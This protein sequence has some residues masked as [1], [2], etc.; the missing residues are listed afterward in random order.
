MTLLPELARRAAERPVVVLDDDPTGTQAVRGLVVMTRWDVDGIARHLA[1]GEPGLFLSTNSRALAE[2]DAVA[3]TTDAARAALEAAERA[4]RPITIVSRGDSTLRGHFP[5]ETRAVASALGRPDA[6]VLLVPYFGEGGRLTLDDVHVLER[7]GARTPV[8]ETEFARDATFGYRA[9]NLRDW[10]V[11]KHAAAGIPPP[12][13]VSLPT[14]LVRDGPGQVATALLEVPPG[15]VAIG[16]AEADADV[17]TIALGSVLAEQD[18]L[19]LVP[20][21]AASFVRARVGQ[22]RAT[23]L[24]PANVPARG[25]GLVVVGSHVTTTTAQVER[26]LAAVPDL[27]VQELT[28]DAVLAGSVAIHHR[29][30]RGVD[31]ALDA[32]RTALVL[33]ERTRRDIDLAGGRAVSAALA[34]IV[35]AVRHRPGWVLAKGGITSFDVARDGLAMAEARIAGP[36]LPGVPVW[37][38][39]DASRWPGV[40][41]VVFPGNVGDTDALAEAV[42]RLSRPG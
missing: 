5:A 22:T 19:S 16:N 12:P 17:E 23:P 3:V 7:D 31:E 25:P 28:I 27:A 39:T 30:A 8:G 21:S 14:G 36:L 20:R 10:V 41:L 9:S 29:I 4:G 32:G 6:R 38:G 18:G 11:E 34:A 13:I 35:G 24:E 1:A 33:T 26:L 37:I 2:P 15:A 42:R 40:P